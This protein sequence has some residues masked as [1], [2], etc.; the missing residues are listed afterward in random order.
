MTFKRITDSNSPDAQKLIDLHSETFPEYERFQETPLLANL[1]DNATPMHFNAIYDNDELAGFFIYWDL[2]NCFYIH[3]ITVFAEM[4]NKKIRQ[5]IMEWISV[6]LHLPVF[7]ESE[8]PYDEITTRRF[9]FYKRNGF[10]ELANDPFIL[11]DV[12]RGGHAPW[13]MG[14]Q[15]VD[16]LDSY[17]TKI[18][19]SVYYATG[20]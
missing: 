13:L 14:T 15:P 1:I 9:N 8:V 3:F 19:D 7:L 10:T 18:R 12:R 4:R 6:N 5:Q 2:E 20:E 17:L 11:S 16:D